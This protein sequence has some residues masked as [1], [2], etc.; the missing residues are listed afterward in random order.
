MSLAAG[1]GPGVLTGDAVAAPAVSAHTPSGKQC[2]VKEIKKVWY[3][4]KSTVCPGLPDELDHL[5]YPGH[6]FTTALAHR[7][8]ERV[9]FIQLRL[10]DRGHTRIVVDGFY[11]DQTRRILKHYQRRHGLVVDGRVG[12]QTWKSLFGLGEA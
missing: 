3:G 9:V 11:G 2:P 4:G 1:A 10:H 6:Q 5:F 12:L 7:Y 8:R